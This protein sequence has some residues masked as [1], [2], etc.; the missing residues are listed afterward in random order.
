MF[1]YDTLAAHHADRH[2]RLV[3]EADAERLARRARAARRTGRAAR[4]SGGD[5]PEGRVSDERRRFAR[6]A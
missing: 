1:P 4:R 6:A 5:A 3:R 2:A